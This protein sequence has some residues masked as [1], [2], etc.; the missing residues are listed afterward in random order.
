[1]RLIGSLNYHMLQA[2]EKADLRAI[3]NHISP[4]DCRYPNWQK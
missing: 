4:A 2:A 1:M 3:L